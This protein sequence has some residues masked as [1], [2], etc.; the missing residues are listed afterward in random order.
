MG[1][2]VLITGVSSG[3]GQALAGLYLE[4][5]C[6]VYGLSRR[7]P[8]E[9]NQHGDFHFASV[10]LKDFTTTAESLDG[11]IAGANIELVI[12]NAGILGAF[13]DMTSTALEVMQEVMDV[14]LWANKVILDSLFQQGVALRQV[15]AISSGASV[16]GARGWNAYG[17][18]KAALNMMMKLYAADRP[19]THFCALAPGLVDSSMQDYLC[20]L[21]NDEA[22][23]VLK[24]LQE[25]KNTI[26]MP[27]PDEAAKLVADCIDK[28]AAVVKSGAYTDVREFTK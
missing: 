7:E 12:L 21:A 1:E 26:Y 5:G 20:N 19:E 9:L 23:P 10:D 6:T 4:R 11:L 15:V 2:G 17:M 24:K 27:S 3:L 14:N 16:S 25:S 13:G 8:A 22:F 28:L 18:S